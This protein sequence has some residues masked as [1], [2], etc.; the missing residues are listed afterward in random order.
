M[1]RLQTDEEQ[2]DV[3]K[4]QIS[5]E[6]DKYIVDGDKEFDTMRDAIKYIQDL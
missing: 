3:Q 6:E 4:H 5:E 1:W 2:D